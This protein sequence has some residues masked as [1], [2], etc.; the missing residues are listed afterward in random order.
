MLKLWEKGMAMSLSNV[1]SLH[2]GESLLWII[3]MAPF[4]LCVL[5]AQIGRGQDRLRQ[6]NEELEARVEAQTQHLEEKAATL[7]AEIEQRGELEQHLRNAK[8]EAESA[9]KTKSEFLSTMSHEIR[10]PMNAVIGMTG[11]LQDTKLN[12]EQ[13]DFVETIRISGANLLAVI[14]DILDFSKIEAGKMEVEEEVLDILEPIE[15]TVDLLSTK[16][17]EK[18][19]E[20]LVAVEKEVPR[21]IRSDL[22]KLRQI[23]LNLTNNALK[24]TEEGEV[25]VRAKYLGKKQSKAEI[26]L[27]VSDTGIG[28]PPERM[29]RLFQ[30]FSQVDASTTRKY[31]GTGLGLII[32]KRMVE[33]LGGRIWVESEEGQG[34]TFFF[35]IL[36]EPAEADWDLPDVSILQGKTALLV[37]DNATN[38]TILEYQCREWGMKYESYRK[39]QD[40]PKQFDQQPKWDLAILD[41]QMPGMTGAELAYALR[42]HAA[43]K[44]LPLLLLSSIGLELPEAEAN[45]FNT[46]LY[47]PARKNHLLKR[48]LGMFGKETEEQHEGI[49]S[50]ADDTVLA[51]QLRPIRILLA[52]DNPINQKVAVRMLEKLG[53]TAE[54][55]GNGKEAF[56]AVQMTPYDLVLMDMQM[57][58]M[59]G[60]EATQAILEKLPPHKTPLIIAMTANAFKEDRDRC[61]E[62]G[63][64][65]YLSKPIQVTTIAEMLLKWFAKDQVPA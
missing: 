1:A 58:I 26:Q 37:D 47:K 35:T 24:F 9:A 33:F 10:T 56:E 42:S 20:L 17:A 32:C 16:A 3:D 15:D 62:A 46:L 49:E 12:E 59:D 22:A 44:H 45:L 4:I 27:S 36:A 64:T 2:A 14:N 60:I 28:I 31:G 50:P 6:A 39:P 25:V 19:I 30:A 38:L 5:A 53:L 23:L 55:A 57:P 21:M 11:M 51:D 52:E 13:A 43:T 34:S 65:D 63:M 48:V 18:E 41:M 61:F 8:V 54:V 7:E 40:V 29:N